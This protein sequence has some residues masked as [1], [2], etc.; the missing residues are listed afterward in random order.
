MLVLS[1]RLDQKIVLPELD[2][3]IQIL[4]CNDSYVKLGFKAPARIRILREELNSRSSV[5]Y[6]SAM[7]GELLGDRVE[8]L[9]R[10]FRHQ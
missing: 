2:V 1:R 6:D 9:P 7:I 3:T 8:R 10:E 4:G 5:P